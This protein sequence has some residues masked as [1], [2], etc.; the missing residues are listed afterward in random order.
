MNTLI[1]F[2]MCELHS[3]EI[4]EIC[5]DCLTGN[6]DCLDCQ[7]YLILRIA[8][9]SPLHQLEYLSYHDRSR[10]W[11]TNTFFLILLWKGSVSWVSL[12]ALAPLPL[13][14][15]QKTWVRADAEQVRTLTPSRGILHAQSF[16]NVPVMK[17]VNCTVRLAN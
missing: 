2:G 9:L 1:E 17:N 4:W 5:Q 6:Q 15:C 12:G 14:S 16:A 11:K 10:R 13:L 3:K 8:F 7:D